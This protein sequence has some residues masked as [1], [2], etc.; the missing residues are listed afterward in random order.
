MPNANA[1]ADISL[2]FPT[3]STTLDGSASIDRDT[4]IVSYL[5]REVSGPAQHTFNDSTLVKPTVGNLTGGTY[6]F[7]LDVTDANGLV[8]ESSVTVTVK[9]DL[10]P[11]AMAGIDVSLTLPANSI[12]LNGNGSSD[13]DGSIAAYRWSK[14]SGPPSYKFN[15]ST[16]VNPVLSNL[17]AGVYTVSLTE[18]DNNGLTA[19]DTLHIKVF[20]PRNTPPVANAG[21]DQT[22]LLPI[23][24]DPSRWIGFERQ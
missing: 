12:Q 7:E 20:P 16:L 19:S 21:P 23:S 9:P 18:A 11:V 14:I 8:G 3:D 24:L 15:D 22:V 1:G 2:S 10:P 13:P 5:W 4:A 17:A 6:I